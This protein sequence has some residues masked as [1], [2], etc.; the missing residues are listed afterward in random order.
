[1]K[2]AAVFVVIVGAAAAAGFGLAVAV[3]ALWG[4]VQGPFQR[5]WDDTWREFVPVALA[6]L[7]WGSTIVAGLT[8]GWRV[9]RRSGP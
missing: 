3:L 8:I 5:E 4:A 9:T 7:V 6:Y 1:M 2:K